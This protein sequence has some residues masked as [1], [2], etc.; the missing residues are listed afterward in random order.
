[1]KTYYRLRIKP[2]LV[3]KIPMRAE[4]VVLI[5]REDMPIS[6]VVR[7]TRYFFLQHVYIA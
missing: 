1:M 5:S 7:N 3:S 6:Q 2:R 4:T